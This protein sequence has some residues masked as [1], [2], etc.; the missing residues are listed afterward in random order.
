MASVSILREVMVVEGSWSHGPQ[1]IQF[2]SMG[3][4]TEEMRLTRSAASVARLKSEYLANGA[5]RVSSAY[6]PTTVYKPLISPI[7][8]LEKRPDRISEARFC[9]HSWV[10]A[11]FAVMVCPFSRKKEAIR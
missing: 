6:T 4:C 9:C 3:C 8:A 5:E 11:N 1:L 10:S 7:A 2:D